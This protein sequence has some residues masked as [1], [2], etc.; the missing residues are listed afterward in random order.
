[1]SEHDPIRLLASLDRPVSMPSG[2]A[3]EIWATV[4]AEL[5]GS[6]SVSRQISREE[7]PPWKG[8]LAATAAAL[9]VLVV[10]LGT[11]ALFTPDQ[12]PVASTTTTVPTTSSTNSLPIAPADVVV[13]TAEDGFVD[14]L[15][16]LDQASARWQPGEDFRYAYQVSVVC[17]C[18]DA[19]ARWVRMFQVPGDG[20]PWDVIPIFSRIRRSIA[21]GATRVEVA[22][23]PDD[24]HTTYFSVQWPESSEGD[25]MVL[26]VDGFH[27]ITFSPSVFDGIYRFTSGEV[28]GEEFGN[29][30]I[31]RAI[32]LT[33]DSGS[34]S[35]PVD[36]NTGGGIVDIYETAFGVGEIVTTE[37]GCPEYTAEA[38]Q[39]TN[40]IRRVE[41]ISEQASELVLSGPGVELRFVTPE[42]AVALG[43]LPLTAAG[44]SVLLEFPDG[45]ARGVVYTIG[46]QEG[47]LG[48]S[49][50]YVLTAEA[51]GV[52][53]TAGWEE[54]NGE[55]EVPDV[56][57]TGPRPDRILIPDTIQNG[58]YR[59]C[60][61]YWKPDPFC[62]DLLVRPASAPWFV[63]AGADGVILH[64]A[65]GTS[66]L[67]TDE[68]TAIAFY[69]DGLIVTWG[70][71]DDSI[72]LRRDGQVSEIALQPGEV[73]LDVGHD[74]DG[75]VA[76]VTNRSSA[77]SAVDLESGERRDIGPASIEARLQDGVALLRRSETGLEARSLQH[78]LLWE[79]TIDA[80][81]MIVPSDPGAVRLDRFGD[82]YID[83]DPAF[84]QFLETQLVD[85]FTGEEL[86]SFEYE[87]AIPLEG[88]Q[89]TE[90]CLRA[91]L[92]EGVLLCPQ[93][94]GRLVTLQVE[95]GDML[96]FP[97]GRGR[98]ATYARQD[99]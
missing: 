29:P 7:R 74:D 30:D 93:P 11:W 81:T 48:Q 61:P 22:F 42:T 80:E 24:G 72:V 10:G 97:P 89:I 66:T 53:S 87:L 47:E 79:A 62:F 58:D 21:D 38:G 92:W 82:L 32:F 71:Q 83:S 94:D 70:V 27:E 57:V 96:D 65:D 78:D 14:V 3:A 73:L 45:R 69:I 19:G 33:L 28:D 51:S 64:D 90:R 35:F 39:F 20:D 86:D 4:D 26:G 59:L 98:I 1:M 75:L 37:V 23:S 55:F 68:A 49:V 50:H 52:D 25:D 12:P 15:A 54:W 41:M 31:G 67:L 36:C 63:T 95:G 43:E 85:V 6:P 77:T 17:D 5:M 56:Q 8:P 13:G 91:E 46:G 84:R 40:G 60:S 2:L 18:P 76:L 16:A 9:V 44:E 34:V 88:D 99:G